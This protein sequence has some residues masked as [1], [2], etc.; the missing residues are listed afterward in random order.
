MRKGNSLYFFNSLFVC[1]LLTFPLVS[2][3]QV[4][5]RFNY[6]G[7]ARD[8]KGNPLSKQTMSLK[9]SVLP[10]ADALTPEYDEIQRVTTNEFGLYTLQIGSGTP[11]LGEMK[12]VKWETG[13]KYIRVAMDPTGGQNFSDAGTTQLLSVPYALYADRAGSAKSGSERTGAVNSNAAHVAGDANFI[14]KFTALNVIGKSLIFDDGTSVGIGTTTPN[15]GFTFHVRRSTNGGHILMENPNA[16]SFGT[17]RM[18]NDVASNFATFTK[19]GST[20]PGGYTGISDKYPF[21]NMLGYGNN[22]PFLNAGTGNIG[23][24]I[25]KNNTNRLKIHIDADKERIGF[26]GNAIP[27]TQIHFNNT[28]A[29]EDTIKFTNQ[30]T[31]HTLG[32]GTE[33]RMN[34]NVTRLMNRENGA[35]I[36]GT[37]NADQVAIGSSGNVGIGTT[38]PA[39]KLDVNG[40]IRIQGGAPGNGKV[41]VSDAA[42]LGSWQLPGI[43]SQWARNGTHIFNNNPGHVGIGTNLPQARLHVSDSSV[44]FSAVG[45]TSITTFNNKPPMEG[46]GRRMM[47]YPD[48]GAFRAGGVV[49]GNSLNW[50]KDSIGAYSVAMGWNTKAKGANAISMGNSNTASGISSTAMGTSTTASGVGATAFGGFTAAT[51]V[52]STAMGDHSIA[53]GDR[54]IAMGE[55]TI[56]SGISSTATG[57]HTV[58][59]GNSSTAMGGGT[60]ANGLASTALGFNTVAN[61]DRATAMGTVTT[62]NGFSSLVIGICNDSIVGAQTTMQPTT[63]LFI[64]GNGTANNARSNV[65]VARNDGRVGIGTNAPAARLHVGDSAV[66]FSANGDTTAASVAIAPPVQGAGRRMMW[67]PEKG[68]FRV[69]GVIGNDSLDWNRDSIGVYSFASGRG[70]KAI[71]QNSTAMGQNSSAVGSASTAMGAGIARGDFSTA[72]GFSQANGD[73]SMAMGF[74]ANATGSGSMAIGFLAVANGGSSVA[75]GSETRA[76]GTGSMAMGANTKAIGGSSTAMGTSSIS[77]GFSSLVIGQFNDTIVAS[78]TSMQTT[79]P[80][81][82]I[83]N[84]T[85]FNA[86]SNVMVARNDGRVGIGTNSPAATLHV[87]GNITI[88]SAETLADSGA[89]T[90]AVVASNFIPS[91]DGARSLGNST[92]RWSTVFASNGTINTSD[93]RD[94]TNIAAI[95]YGLSALMQLKP[96]HFN[97]K[98]NPE[99]GTK[100]GFLAQ[101]LQKIIPEV[102]ADKEFVVTDELTG[103]GEWKPMNRLGVY[104]SD[105]IPV[106]TKAIQEQQSQI[107]MQQS[108]IETQQTQIDTLLK[109]NELQQKQNQQLLQRLEA[110]EKK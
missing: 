44:V 54:S 71:G 31:G 62:A 87:N 88:G 98:N 104:Y 45:D 81:F 8:T 75:M 27:Q 43:D 3:A 95:P 35:L 16:N 60:N 94:K 46:A 100:L 12:T 89:N 40:Q 19:Y 50:N 84:G 72:M 56:A 20:F 110:L 70:T 101:D 61:G 91:G 22:G 59:S 30:T 74:G 33:L 39:G 63:P 93:A 36:L 37:N 5:Q 85:A 69:G 15:S 52:A 7:I 42:G 17:F 76:D 49:G 65:L 102:V 109:Q 83:G 34:G 80:I 25:T 48:R 57:F 47:W 4:P 105:L 23:F 1:L 66:V 82:I 67:Y 96:V 92:H 68:A 73:F 26:G 2:R 51:G 32:D 24:A 103:A 6:Q 107:Q 79:T 108:E 10:A 11:M 97:W 58:A 28:D 90:L 38:A 18:I 13:N 86:R 14:T 53:S 9:L 99:A 41:L 64:V 55:F 78:Q 106:L 21:A 77:N 29:G